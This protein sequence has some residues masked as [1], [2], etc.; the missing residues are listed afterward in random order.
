MFYDSSVLNNYIQ[1]VG[2]HYPNVL[3]NNIPIS[4]TPYSG[5]LDTYGYGIS[6]STKRA[7]TRFIYIKDALRIGVNTG[8]ILKRIYYYDENYG[9]LSK[10]DLS[11]QYK[12][13]NTNAHYIKV[14]VSKTDDTQDI[15]TL[16]LITVSVYGTPNNMAASTIIPKYVQNKM[17]ID[18]NWSSWS[19]ERYSWGFNVNETPIYEE[20]DGIFEANMLSVR[21]GKGRW[22]STSGVFENGGHILE[23]RNK[24]ENVRFT[25]LMGKY[26]DKMSCIQTYGS[27]GLNGGN[28][29]WGYVKI[30]SDNAYEGLNIGAKAL[31][32]FVPICLSTTQPTEVTEM[33]YEFGSSTSVPVGA[34]YYDTTEQSICVMT[35]SGWKKC[36]LED[37]S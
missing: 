16:S 19:N 23:G 6:S 20:F 33:T 36:K 9:Y 21:G 10:E 22:N 8:Y 26:D 12:K 1:I 5:S 7:H 32:S 2:Y 29:V 24:N 4:E 11:V 37:M 25:I 18:P 15:G 13:L 27:P 28:R 3:Q 30:G 14:V 31:R 35:S 34:M 17:P